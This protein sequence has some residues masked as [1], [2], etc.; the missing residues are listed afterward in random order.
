VARLA[1]TLLALALAGGTA[2]AFAVTER[3][4]LEPTPITDT[5]IVPPSRVF[6]PVCRCETASAEIG[7]QLREGGRVTVDL[8]D[9]DDHSVR[10][11]ADRRYGA[12][13]HRFAWD[14]RDS[15]GRVVPEA[16][17]RPRVRLDGGARTIV[18]PNPIR[19]DTTPP[20][21]EL[22]EHRPRDHISPDGD[23]RN[24]RL[25]AF[26]QVSE[27]ANGLLF[28]NGV[29]RV[30]TRFQRLED[31]LDW[32]GRIGGRAVRPGTYRVE[33]GAVD[34][35]GNLAPRTPAVAIDVRYIE[36]ARDVIPA[37]ARLRF[38]VRVATDAPTYRWR[39]AGGTGL[40]RPGLL[41]LRAPR[42]P[43]RYRLYVWAHG[44]ADSARV[45][46]SPRR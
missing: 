44:H 42:N 21:I 25:T 12:G 8:L 30:R 28:V 41:V 24:D 22:R 40:G 29:Q 3:L 35:A 38:G 13:F 34:E 11:I 2:A 43:G 10:T 5:R 17:Y 26:Y 15:D 18:L 39:F 33:L 37:R 4:K 36:L 27:P 19:V 9:A 46:V 7:F 6:S 16:S 14:G 1:P 23:G 45:A 31:K 20:E 32:Y